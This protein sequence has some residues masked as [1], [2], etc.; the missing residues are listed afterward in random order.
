MKTIYIAGKVTGIPTH[1]V[2]AKFDQAAQKL[3]AAGF[4]VVNPVELVDDPSTVWHL[5][6]RKC[7]AALMLCDAILLLP[8]WKSSAGASI[9]AQISA[10]VELP[11]FE[12]HWLLTQHFKTDELAENLHN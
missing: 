1:E 3:I 5:A 10:I 6:M 12:S 4:K 9:E 11:F 8:D 2:K 7:I